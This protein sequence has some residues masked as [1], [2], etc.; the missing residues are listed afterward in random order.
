M[1][2][3]V[4]KC[5]QV[6]YYYVICL[7]YQLYQLCLNLGKWKFEYVRLTFP[8]EP[9][10]TIIKIRLSPSPGNTR[11]STP[12][13]RLNT[14]KIFPQQLQDLTGRWWSLAWYVPNLSYADTPLHSFLFRLLL[15]RIQSLSED[16][17]SVTSPLRT[18]QS[19]HA[20]D[21]VNKENIKEPLL[22]RASRTPK[23]NP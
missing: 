14:L 2:V 12:P 19:L 11:T 8:W 20:V 9:Q 22:I 18:P 4:C 17:G 3:C 21:K 7:P 6:Y 16:S 15:A 1:Y 13:P 10:H 23:T 5:S